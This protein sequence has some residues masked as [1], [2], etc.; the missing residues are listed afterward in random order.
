[1]VPSKYCLIAIAILMVFM[2]TNQANASNQ[3][4]T[5]YNIL[6]VEYSQG[7]TT[8]IKNNIISDCPP[9]IKIYKYDTTNKNIS[10]K[11]VIVKDKMIREKPEITNHYMFYKNMVVCIDCKIDLFH[12]DLV[13]TIFLEPTNFIYTNKNEVVTKNTFTTYTDRYVSE[14]CSTS[15][16]AYSDRMLNDTINYML[17]GC[18]KTSLHLNQ[19]NNVPYHP[20]DYK[21]S[22][23][24]KYKAWLDTIKQLHNQNCIFKK[25]VTPSTKKW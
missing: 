7:C 18:T 21:D 9:L 11:F 12:P 15:T 24:Y 2:V 25:C 23:W 22:I 19:T 14:D 20:P 17:S 6:A 5:R 8:M 1:M 16:I 4:S 10:G 13:K 3:N